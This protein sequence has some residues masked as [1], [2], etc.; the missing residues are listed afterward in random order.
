MRTRSRLIAYVCL[1]IVS[2]C[3]A[4]AQARPLDDITESGYIRI[5]VYQDFPPFSSV[6]DGHLVGVD[7]DLANAIADHLG[8]RLEVMPIT[9]GEK[10]DDD[11]R[12]AVWRGHLIDRTIADLMLHVPID[13]QFAAR[14]KLV[15]FFAP[16]ARKRFVVATNE[17]LAFDPRNLTSLQ[18]ERIGVELDTMPDFFLSS[19]FGGQLRNAVVRFKTVSAATQAFLNGDV[20]VLMATRSEIESA[21]GPAREGIRLAPMH[22]A[23]FGKS[24]WV[25]GVAVDENSRDVGYAVEDIVAALMQSGSL[26]R[27]FANHGLSYEPPAEPE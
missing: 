13:R 24:S 9:A 25:I 17:D 6:R 1:V 7:I 18:N 16:Y 11:L 21:L 26:E 20:S 8:V 14:N 23:G 4:E 12:N 10:V 5:A 27:I 19:A 22:M 15:S 3:T 2:I